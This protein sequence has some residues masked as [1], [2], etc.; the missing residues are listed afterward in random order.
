MLIQ[1]IR[2][3]PMLLRRSPTCWYLPMI[4]LSWETTVV[5]VL[6]SRD[7]GFVPRANII[8]RA[9]LSTGHLGEQ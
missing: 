8:G 2:A 6:D 5:V 1:A 4:I 3:T 7:W 9:A